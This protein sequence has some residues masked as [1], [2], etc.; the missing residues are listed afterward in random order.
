MEE[1]VNFGSRAQSSFVGAQ[2]VL[3]IYCL[4]KY[5]KDDDFLKK[6]NYTTQP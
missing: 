1:I 3:H 5:I 4:F 6:D 2:E